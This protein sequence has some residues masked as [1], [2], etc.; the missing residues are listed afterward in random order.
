MATTRSQQRSTKNQTKSQKSEKKAIAEAQPLDGTALTV[1]VDKVWT[2]VGSAGTLDETSVGKVRFDHGI[3][4]M[5][6]VI[7]DPLPTTQNALIGQETETA[8]IRY[9]VTPV[10]G[11]FTLIATPCNPG[12]NAA[13]KL[14][15]RYI[16]VGNASVVANLI[17][18]D[19]ASGDETVRLT[20]NGSPTSN[21]YQVQDGNLNCGPDFSFDFRSKAYYIEATLTAVTQFAG[22]A[23]G[24]H[25]IKIQTDFFNA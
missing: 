24:I 20:F 11:L 9:N 25:I 8:V 6:I 7:N 21:H 17:E 14:T 19:L 4:Q 12:P 18:V 3:V 16:A 5:G 22:N 1:A 13:Y 23:A 15:L 2:T 10:D